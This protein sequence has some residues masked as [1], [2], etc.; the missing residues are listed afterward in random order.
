MYQKEI[1]QTDIS[2]NE[3]LRF[4]TPSNY[5]QILERLMEANIIFSTDRNENGSH[6]KKSSFVRGCSFPD[7]AEV[8][9]W[10]TAVMDDAAVRYGFPGIGELTLE[11]RVDELMGTDVPKEIVKE[12]KKQKNPF[13][14][15]LDSLG[16]L[17]EEIVE[18]EK[19]AVVFVSAPYCQLCRVI[20]PVYTRM[21][22]ISIE[23]EGNDLAF[24]KASSAGKTGKQMTTVLGIESVPTFLLFKAGEQYGEPFGATKLPSAVL[25][26]V[27]DNLL[28]DKDWDSTL[29]NKDE[30]S[31]RTKLNT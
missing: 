5:G 11:A 15:E 19:N 12:K 22:R 30:L 29:I 26:A 7:Y 1:E 6:Q 14:M 28:N 27:I 13:V 10:P 17:R 20:S 4:P 23:E 25:D 21:A 9:I 3:L 2:S 16:D 24:A 18:K 8:E 31:G